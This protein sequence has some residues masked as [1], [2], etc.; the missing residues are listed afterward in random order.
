MTGSGKPRLA[1]RPRVVERDEALQRAKDLFWSLGY[2]RASLPELERATGLQ[3][4]SLYALFSDKRELFLE[5]LDL[6]GREGLATMDATM[7]AGARRADI[8]A[9]IRVHAA[10]AHGPAGVRGCF[11]VE[12][13]VEMGPHDPV[14]AERAAAIFAAMLKRL[15]RA[16]A[17]AGDAQVPDPEAAA[18]TLL[19]GL[20]G[21]RVFG[22]AGQSED[23]VARAVGVLAATLVPPKPAS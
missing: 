3:R 12:T 8:L 19:A 5:A 18:R 17:G 13:T 1:G 4:G 20:E 14:I 7:P 16:L 22:K 15:E 2:Q 11:L 9:W 23:E 6:Y 10:R 21:L